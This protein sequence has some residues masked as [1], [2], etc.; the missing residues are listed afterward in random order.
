MTYVNS[1][2]T[3][4]KNI[5]VT[6][7]GIAIGELADEG[8]PL[9]IATTED[10]EVT[11]QDSGDFKE[12]K[13]GRRDGG[14][15]EIT[16]NYVASDAGQQALAAA[17]DAGSVDLYRVT[18]PSGS[19]WEFYAVSKTF[20]TPIKNKMIMYSAKVKVTGKP[21]LSTTVA[22]LTTPFFAVAAGGGTGTITISPAA[23]EDEGTYIV[24]AANGVTGVTVTPTCATAGATIKVDNVTVATGVASAN[25]AL[26]AGTPKEVLIQVFESGKATG[27]YKLLCLRASS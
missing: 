22:K 8:I 7:N 18:L 15:C 20:S 6:I 26:T 11:N 21:V 25:K 1:Q 10:I 9:P 24:N 13:Q 12:F 3:V 2:A 5:V 4:A 23:A 27:H 19:Y 16:G 17:A 14:E